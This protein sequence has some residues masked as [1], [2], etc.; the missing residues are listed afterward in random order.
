MLT[1]NANAILTA[2]NMDE[3]S[4][5]ITLDDMSMLINN[6]KIV[7]DCQDD[8]DAI[9]LFETS[10]FNNNGEMEVEADN[11]G[12][13]ADGSST[14]NNNGLISISLCDNEAIDLSDSAMFFNM[15]SGIIMI[16]ST[17]EE[18]IEMDNSSFFENRGMI[19]IDNVSDSPTDNSSGDGICVDDSGS[20]F[21]NYGEININKSIAS[22]EGIEVDDGLF[23][24]Y[25]AGKITITNMDGAS[26]YLESGCIF[27]NEGMITISNLDSVNKQPAI[28]FT[29]ESKL[30]N[31]GRITIAL[32]CM[33]TEEAIS[34]ST[35]DTLVNENF[36]VIDIITDHEISL[37]DSDALVDNFGVISSAYTGTNNNQGRIVNEGSAYLLSDNGF[38]A[39]P[40]AV[41]DNGGTIQGRCDDIDEIS[42]CLED[43]CSET[44]PTLSEWG[45]IVL[46]LFLLVIAI[47]AL[48]QKNMTYT[49]SRL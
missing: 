9:C 6:G 48:K 4:A 19:Q 20:Q 37:D 3:N 38:L 21:H 41:E 30:I 23:H 22:A 40:N 12:I 34:M 32:N 11:D 42:T 24:N 49:N 1:I 29:H 2:I 46:A 33:S 13:E 7:A 36:G 14:F 43:P 5:A 39:S 44:I 15:S 35:T 28:D 26:I 47:I 10:T 8:N 31:S 25:A 45:L 16:D 27:E 18:G 17:D